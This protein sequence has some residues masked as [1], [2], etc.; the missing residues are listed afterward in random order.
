[1]S[2]QLLDVPAGKIAA[3]VTSLE[4][5]ERPAPRPERSARGLTL[6]HI[7]NPDLA[8]FRGLFRRVGE[9]WLWFSRLV[10]SDAELAAIVHDPRVE[11]YVLKAGADEAGLL[12]LDF[13][14]ADECEL[15]FFGLAPAFVGTGAGRWLMNR[16]IERAWARPIRRFWVHTCTVDH[17][18]ALAF[19]VRSGFRPF[20]QQIELADDPRLSGLLRRSA[21]P[22]V[23]LI[24]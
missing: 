6:Q 21:A 13:R 3:V 9:N 11:V 18:A 20:R 19:Y 8:W 15:S 7:A 17:Q 5:L 2:S 12:E 14:A 24:D 16:A 22:H 10:M 4:M 1:M 23:P